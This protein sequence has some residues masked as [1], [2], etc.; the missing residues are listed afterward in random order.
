[1][2]GLYRF[3]RARGWV[4]GLGLAL[5]A[6]STDAVA[7]GEDAAAETET[8]T[9]HV[10]MVK[11]EIKQESGKVVKNSGDVVEWNKD[12]K[13]VIEADEHKHDVSLKVG[14]EGDK[15]KKLNVTLA[16]DRDGEAVIA[17]YSFDTRVKKR[18]V[19]RIEGG[20]AIAVTVTPKTVKVEA[21]KKKKRDK[22][23]GA[24]DP[25]DPLDGLE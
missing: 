11:V 2:L 16:Y 7:A 12:A 6:V 8:Q 22:I 18:E 15:S 1:M 9:K 20:I 14:R 23:S 5:A 3:V 13:V 17:P 10:A 21:P 4:L 24:E 25:T 19:I